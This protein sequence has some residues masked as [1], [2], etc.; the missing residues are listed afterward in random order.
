MN[1]LVLV[2]FFNSDEWMFSFKKLVKSILS[3][4]NTEFPSLHDL[5]GNVPTS[6]LTEDCICYYK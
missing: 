2:D 3:L 1:V 5:I 4:T 6:V